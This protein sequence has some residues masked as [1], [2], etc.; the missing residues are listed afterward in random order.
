MRF[1]VIILSATIFFSSCS[2]KREERDLV[3]NKVFHIYEENWITGKLN[4]KSIYFYEN[5]NV[6]MELNYKAGKIDGEY[7][8]YYRNKNLKFRVEYRND[9][10]WNV[11]GYYDEKGN[12]LDYGYLKDGNGYIKKYDSDG[13]IKEEGQVKNG[14]REGLWKSY[15]K[16]KPFYEKTYNKGKE[17]GLKNVIIK[18]IFY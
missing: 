11:L 1:L 15:L 8:A 3:T 5:G 13:L 18:P 4:G 2:I 7:S 12:E 10:L 9:L 16:G 14:L 17:V 6:D